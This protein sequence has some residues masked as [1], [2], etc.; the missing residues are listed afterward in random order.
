MDSDSTNGVVNPKREW[1][2]CLGTWARAEAG[3][4]TLAGA[5]AGSRRVEVQQS[6]GWCPNNINPVSSHKQS[7]QGRPECHYAGGLDWFEWSSLV[8]WKRAEFVRLTNTLE[9]AKRWHKPTRCR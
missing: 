2:R 8:E 9:T 5:A 4:S 3:P 1:V 6:G 7:L